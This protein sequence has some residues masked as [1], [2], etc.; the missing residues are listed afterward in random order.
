MPKADDG[1]LGA[2]ESLVENARNKTVD[3]KKFTRQIWL[4]G[5]GAYAKDDDDAEFKELVKEGKV[6]EKKSKD[7]KVKHSPHQKNTTESGNTWQKL[8]SAF[9]E[10]LSAA[11]GRLGICSHSDIESLNSELDQL[12]KLIEELS[13]PDDDEE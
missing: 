10:R 4:A 7:Q 8:E 13:K 11:L 6:Y 12:T 3:V 2:F 1:N 9:D 5:L